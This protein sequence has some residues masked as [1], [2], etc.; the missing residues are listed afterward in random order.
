LRLHRA[1]AALA[2]EPEI[3]DVLDVLISLRIAVA[4]ESRPER[5]E[6]SSQ[7]WRQ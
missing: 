5:S 6:P 1:E 4:A 2:A 3:A 7:A